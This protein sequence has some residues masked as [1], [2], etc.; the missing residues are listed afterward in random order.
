MLKIFSTQL[1]GKFKPFVDDETSIEEAARLLAQ[2]IVGEGNVY[3]YGT[4]EMGGVLSEAL[5]GLEPFP[6]AKSLEWIAG[7]LPCTPIDRA[8]VFSRFSQDEEA[9]KI[10]QTL[11]QQG[12]P[13]VAISS[14]EKKDEMGL[15]TIADVH[16]DIKLLKGLLPDELGNRFGYPALMLGLFVYH[17]IKFTLDEILGEL[18]E[19]EEEI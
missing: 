7:E 10:A 19:E 13:F 14:V 8:L 15:H 2:A 1:Q 9:L 6:R 11:E 17:G 3:L 12:I 16:I 4:D 5:F 18:E